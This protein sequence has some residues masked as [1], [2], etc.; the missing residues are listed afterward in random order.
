MFDSFATPWTVARQPPL[1][2]GFS[3]QEY[4]SG[5]P[6][7]PAGD[8]PRFCCTAGGSPAS[9]ADSLRLSLPGSPFFFRKA[10][11]RKKHSILPSSHVLHPPRLFQAV[12]WT[13]PKFQ[14]HV[15]SYSTLCYWKTS[16]HQ[17]TQAPVSCHLRWC[18]SRYTHLDL[19]SSLLPMWIEG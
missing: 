9:K 3:G 17:S 13:S 18:L 10:S 16:R 7:P 2:L 5:F 11:K 15:Q 6:F 4:C 14:P 12:T 19:I 8:L 1:S